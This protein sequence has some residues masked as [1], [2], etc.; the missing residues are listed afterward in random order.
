MYLESLS[1][2]V[3]LPPTM[4]ILEIYSLI[5]PIF[6][7][8]AKTIHSSHIIHFISFLSFKVICLAFCFFFLFTLD[9]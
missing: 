1:S 9:K 7:N 2:D 4:L 8:I 3:L 5:K 6:K